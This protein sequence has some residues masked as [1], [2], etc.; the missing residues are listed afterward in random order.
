MKVINNVIFYL[1]CKLVKQWNTLKSRQFLQAGGAVYSRPGGHSRLDF[2]RSAESA[3]FNP[4]EERV[5]R[6]SAGSLQ[7][8]G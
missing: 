3:V 5:Q 6:R 1:L 4:Q 2:R 7:N 8:S